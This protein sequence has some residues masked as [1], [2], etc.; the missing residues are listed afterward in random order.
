MRFYY[1]LKNA[2]FSI[3]AKRTVGVRV[4]LINE[5]KIL[6]VKHTY[7][8]DW[9]TIGGGVDPGETPRQALEREL[10]EE[11]GVTLLS[12]PE[13]FSVYYSRNKKHDD[14][15]IF[16]TAHGCTQHVVT[17]PEIAEQQWFALNE[18]PVDLSP[19]TR[20]RIEEYFEKR[21]ISEYWKV[22]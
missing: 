19:A 6:L 3:V 17:S 7:Q 16:Y 12:A 8:P 20:R 18:L 5:D 2:I 15:I 14:Y 1:L 13:L 11:V 4:L 10:Q 22:S 9:Y 21:E